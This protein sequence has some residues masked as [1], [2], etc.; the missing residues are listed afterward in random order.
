MRREASC[1][2][3]PGGLIAACRRWVAEGRIVGGSVLIWQGGRERYFRAGGGGWLGSGSGSPVC[4]RYVAADIFDDQAG[5]RDCTDAIVGTGQ[6]CC[7]MIHWHN[8]C[9]NLPMRA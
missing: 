1:G 2:L 8:I 9:P 5:Y 7:W 6:I 4:T 3:I